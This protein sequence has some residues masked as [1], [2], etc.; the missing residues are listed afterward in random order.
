MDKTEARDVL[1]KQ[2]EHL[3]RLSYA[4]LLSRVERSE[5]NEVSG[6]S[7]TK[8]QVQVEVFLGRARGREPAGDRRH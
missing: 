6:P 8:Y 4:E 1:T 3:R 7:G 2:I 5:T